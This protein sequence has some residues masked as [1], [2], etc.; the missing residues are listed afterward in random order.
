MLFSVKP[1]DEDRPLIYLLDPKVREMDPWKT[2]VSNI[3]DF[4]VQFQRHKN[5]NK[6]CRRASAGGF[7]LD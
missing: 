6:K 3:I 2:S 7:K 1:N 4:A 5:G